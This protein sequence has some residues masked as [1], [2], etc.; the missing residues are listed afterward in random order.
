MLAV[1]NDGQRCCKEVV[2]RSDTVSSFHTH[3]RWLWQATG[4]G[5]IK[6]SLTVMMYHRLYTHTLALAVA[7]DGQ[8]CSKEVVDR[9]DV[10]SFL[11]THTSI[12]C[13]KRR[14]EVL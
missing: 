3:W 13:G 9:S 1:A 7:S 8:R 10:P 11:Y 4:R 14:E 6:K 5:A 12:G 2:D